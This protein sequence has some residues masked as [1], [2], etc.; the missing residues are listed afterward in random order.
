MR[1]VVNFSNGSY[2]GKQQRL[3]QSMAKYGYRTFAYQDY[4]Q[5]GSTTHQQ[6]PYGFKLY[7][8]QKAVEQGATTILY[9]DS[10]IWAIKD[11][12]P[13]FEIIENEGYLMQE[14]GHYVGRWANDECLNYFGITREE[15]N[16]MPMYGNAGLL[17]LNMNQEIANSFM[18]A[19]FES[20]RAGAF[21]GTWDNHRHD[22][23]CGSIIANQLGMKYKSGN[24]IL[25]YAGPNDPVNESIILKAQG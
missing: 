22:M 6:D 10:S 7:A 19:W 1:A 4:S 11:P 5:I 20:L 21:R 8:I 17:G 16:K 15:A 2:L 25:A 13:L 12:T 24:E 14:A 3:I 18:D 9:C 23:T